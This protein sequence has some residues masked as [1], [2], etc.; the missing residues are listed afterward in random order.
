MNR[1]VVIAVGV[2]V[3]WL[4]ASSYIFNK[5]AFQ[6]GVGPFMLAGMR[7][8]VAVL[9]FVLFALFN[10]LRKRIKSGGLVERPR[11][12]LSFM[13]YLLLGVT[14]FVMAQ[15]LQY[16]GQLYL[17][18]TQT[19]LVLSI[20]NMLFVFLVDLIWLREIRN[21]A[22]FVGAIVVV[23]GILSYYYPWN[24]GWDS[25]IGIFL[26]LLSCL[27]YAINLTA[28]RHFLTE[29]KVQPGQLVIYPMLIG[30]VFMVLIGLIKEGLPEVN[31][32][33]IGI[34]L[35]LGTVNGALA[36][37][38]WAWT[39]KT[40][41]AYESSILNNLVMPEVA[42]LD[43]LVFS[44]SLSFLQFVGLFLTLAGIA[45]IQFSPLFKKRPAESISSHKS[46]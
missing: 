46:G 44:R 27:G 5:F 39:Q 9:T 2:L 40:L 18:P 29:K 22:I 19:S 17:T 34:V 12:G 38:L 30:A 20:G 23:A 13:Q 21:K 10:R 8:S 4:W 31:A 35:W 33:L 42:L 26:V 45:Y 1:L 14:G 25:G 15:G 24:I 7:Y 28:T 43:V 3:T 32:S 6:D 16:G 11:A 37:Y 36:F 41:K